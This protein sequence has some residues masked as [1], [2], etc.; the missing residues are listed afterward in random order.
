MPLPPFLAIVF[1]IK[2]V[3]EWL[4]VG[5]RQFFSGPGHATGQEE[6]RSLRV[7]WWTTMGWLLAFE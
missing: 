3:V 2:F 4:E 7:R 1:V 6:A 5:V